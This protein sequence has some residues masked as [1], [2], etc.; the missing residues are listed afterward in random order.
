MPFITRRNF[1]QEQQIFNFSD[2][3]IVTSNVQV[4]AD[5]I[6]PNATGEKLISAGTFVASVDDVIRFLP[7]AKVTTAFGTGSTT[8]VVTP[9]QVF[10]AGDVLSVVE[11]QAT[12]TIGGTVAA[13]DTVTITIDNKEITVT[14]TTTTLADLVALAV[15]AINTNPITKDI[16]KAISSGGVIYLYAIDGIST[17]TIAVAKVGTNVTVAVGGSA[18]KFAYVSVGTVSSVAPTTGTITLTGNASVV[19]PIGANIGVRVDT[20]LGLD[21][22]DREFNYQVVQHF[23]LY[24]GSDGVKENLLPYIDGDLKRRFNR[25]NFN[26]KF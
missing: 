3:N 16:V 26:T 5:K 9:S 8:G 22:H 1:E 10:V 20:V 18:T 4:D 7:R 2:G 17:Y 14:A 21:N 6:T 25:I 19:V 13:D 12:V 15:T 24:T 11:P 23:G